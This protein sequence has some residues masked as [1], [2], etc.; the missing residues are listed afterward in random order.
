MPAT[1]FSALHLI[2]FPLLL[3]ITAFAYLLRKNRKVVDGSLPPG[4]LGLP[5]VGETLRLINAYRTENPEPF[6]DE[7]LRRNGTR[8]FTTPLFGE[9][10]VF[11]L[12]RNSTVSFSAAR[13]AP[14]RA[15]TLP[16]SPPSL[17]ATLSFS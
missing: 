9:L 16:P 7:R 11:P 2:F 3:S 17:G 14:L 13:V 12:T 1:A 6:V 5:F 8:L 15:A 4:S 10:T